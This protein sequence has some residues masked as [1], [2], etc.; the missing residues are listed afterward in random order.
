MDD[1]NLI[2]YHK[3]GFI[4]GP[5]ETEEEFL[6]RV[7][8]TRNF[9]THPQ[10]FLEENKIASPFSLEDR[11]K[12]PDKH[13]SRSLLMR[14]FELNHDL[15]PAFFSN[16]KLPFFQGGAT[17]L[18]DVKSS[19][20]WVKLPLLQIRKPFK[21]GSFLKIYSLDEILAHEAIHAARIGFQENIYEEYIAYLSSQKMYRRILG[22]LFTSEKES[23]AF[24]FLSLL[25]F[26][27]YTFISSSFLAVFSLWSLSAFLGYTFIRLA[28][29]KSF[30][31][32]TLKK[33]SKFFLSKEKGLSLLI[34]LTDKEIKNFALWDMNK[35]LSYIKNES[36]KS[37][38]IKMIKVNYF[39]SKENL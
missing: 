12:K 31:A 20:K 3:E 19:S 2:E 39:S 29:R 35:I 9:F 27:S 32:R 17:W 4:P 26:A 15:F 28:F 37:L 21:K 1:K 33:L 14:R 13:W 5:L 30:L 23:Y 18:I 38:R 7:E 36:N 34:R 11:V 25:V 22:P 8:A 16:E 24:I 10:K 6:F